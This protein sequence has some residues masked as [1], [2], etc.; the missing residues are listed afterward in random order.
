[1]LLV[2]IDHI[3]GKELQALR[4][5]KGA[6]VHSKHAGKDLMAGLKGLVGGEIKGY[7]DMLAEARQIATQRMVE[8]AEALMADAVVNVRYSSVEV[9]DG[10]AEVL[11]YGT[12]VRY[13]Q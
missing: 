6:V 7:T 12:A 3:P 8:E 2:N 13:A 5:V 9:M 1:M 4:M 11:V 10:A